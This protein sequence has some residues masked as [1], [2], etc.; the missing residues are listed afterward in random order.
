MTNTKYPEFSL[1]RL[2]LNT[3]KPKPNERI[4]IL[5]DLPDISLVK[6]WAF[7]N[8]DK[9]SI[10]RHAYESFYKT[11]HAEVLAAP[12]MERPWLSNVRL[13]CLEPSSVRRR[14]APPRL[15]LLVFAVV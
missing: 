5:I 10:Q 12:W 13:R 3:F 1:S 2:L 11:L 14:P 15:R 4:C 7:L 9:F 8:D 6:N